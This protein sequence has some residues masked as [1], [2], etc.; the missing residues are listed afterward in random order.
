M[1]MVW[2][3]SSYVGRVSK[4]MASFLTGQ[5]GA[6]GVVSKA[7]LKSTSG[8]SMVRISFPERTD[9]QLYVCAFY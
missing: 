1:K 8:T 4:Y 3:N 5:V 7:D 2:K 6:H 9:F